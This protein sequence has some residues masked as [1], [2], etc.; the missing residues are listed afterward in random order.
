MQILDDKVIGRRLIEQSSTHLCEPV[1]EEELALSA[2]V[3]TSAHLTHFFICIQLSPDI[4]DPRGFRER[5][6]RRPE[7]SEGTTVLGPGQ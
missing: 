5:E 2:G 3:R 6:I 7:R 4:V 1:E